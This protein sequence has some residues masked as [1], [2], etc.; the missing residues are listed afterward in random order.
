MRWYHLCV[1][2]TFSRARPSC[3]RWLWTS[4]AG[5]PAWYS[6]IIWGRSTYLKKTWPSSSSLRF[7]AGLPSSVVPHVPTTVWTQRSCQPRAIKSTS[8]SV[9]VAAIQLPRSAGQRRLSAASGYFLWAVLTGPMKWRPRFLSWTAV[10]TELNQES[11]T[12]ILPLPCHGWPKSGG[13]CCSVSRMPALSCILFF[14]FVELNANHDSWQCI[15]NG[16]CFTA[17]SFWLTLYFDHP[18]QSPRTVAL[19]VPGKHALIHSDFVTW[20]ERFLPCG[21][22]AI[23]ES[24]DQGPLVGFLSPLFLIIVTIRIAK[25]KCT[26]NVLK[27]VI[28]HIE[29]SAK[30]RSWKDTILDT[31]V[32]S[33]GLQLLL[34]KGYQRPCIAHSVKLLSSFQASSCSYRRVCDQFLPRE[35]RASSIRSR[36]ELVGFLCQ[37][38]VCWKTFLDKRFRG[39]HLENAMS[40]HCLRQLRSRARCFPDQLSNHLSYLRCHRLSQLTQESLLLLLSL[41]SFQ[42]SQDCDRPKQMMNEMSQFLRWTQ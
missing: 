20:P 32:L 12:T 4:R 27:T 31:P 26:Q 6:S 14:P 25:N 7:L 35:R 41:K 13:R 39:F 10:L 3:L 5:A 21:V 17:N 11:P 9:A 1:P 36:Q 22:A 18:W 23:H 24:T 33:A 29:T 30:R 28:S 40:S 8:S 34:R 42:K 2:H 15:G 16:F 38:V 37:A 19:A